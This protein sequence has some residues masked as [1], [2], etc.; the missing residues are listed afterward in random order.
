[1]RLSSSIKNQKSSLTVHLAT[2]LRLQ[3]RTNIAADVT[4][5]LVTSA[6]DVS[7][8]LTPP[9]AEPDPRQNETDTKG[10]QGGAASRVC[11]RGEA[12]TLDE[13]QSTPET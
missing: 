2:V 8:D 13:G 11:V 10:A 4:G 7:A 5:T 9:A 12:H 1:M 6:R 3:Q